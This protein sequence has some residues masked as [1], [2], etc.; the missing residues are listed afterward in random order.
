MSLNIFI[1]KTAMQKRGAGAGSTPVI[2]IPLGDATADAFA[3]SADINLEDKT[4]GV[5]RPS[6]VTTF[7]NGNKVTT[8][9]E[10]K[11]VLRLGDNADSKLSPN[12]L[13]FVRENGESPVTQITFTNGDDEYTFD[14]NIGKLNLESIIRDAQEKGFGNVDI[15]EAL[16]MDE[17]KGIT[18]SNALFKAKDLTPKQIAKLRNSLITLR[19]SLIGHKAKELR[20]RGKNIQAFLLENKDKLLAGG[21]GLAAGS[22]GYIGAYS[23]LGLIPYMK[24]RKALRFLSSLLLGAG[25]GTAA[26]LLTHKF[27]TRHYTKS[28]EATPTDLAG[29]VG[30]GLE[31]VS[32]I[33][34]FQKM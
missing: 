11:V 5:T 31:E 25:T 17:Y 33:G 16:Y 24:Q 10:G 20:S 9:T 18:P 34:K 7:P 4:V 1:I 8:G 26:G 30:K 13:E 19:A 23:G 6:T 14:A 28:D 15:G 3:D 12:S 29:T 2:S 22:L 27:L 32:D 21:T